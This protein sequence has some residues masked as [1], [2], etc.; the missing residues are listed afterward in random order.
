MKGTPGAAGFDLCSPCYYVIPAYGSKLIPTDL[1]INLPEDSCGRILLRSSL[2]L[3]HSIITMAGVIDSDFRGNLAVL[4]FNLSARPFFVEPGLKICQFVI[5]K[6]Y[7]PHIK[8]CASLDDT[9]RGDGC[10][11]STNLL[12]RSEKSQTV[13][14]WMWITVHCDHNNPAPGDAIKE[15]TQFY[16]NKETAV[17]AGQRWY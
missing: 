17:S 4:L 11:G 6:I 16:S 13:Y 3:T 7:T 12:K 8:E 5:H 14:H 10:F 1:A 9:I 2:S 15:G